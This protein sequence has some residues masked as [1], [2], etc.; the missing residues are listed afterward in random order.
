[1][2]EMRLIA[3]LAVLALAAGCAQ[4]TAQGPTPSLSPE[5]S[6]GP[7]PTAATTPSPPLP[8]PTAA[9]VTKGSFKLT[10][11]AA[12]LKSPIYVTAAGDGSDRL[13]VVEQPGRILV[14]KNGQVLPRPFLDIRSLVAYGGERGLLGLAFHPDFG[15]NGVFVVDYTR[16]SGHVGDTVIARYKAVPGSDVAD[17]TSAQVLMVISQPQ[18][19]HNGGM[20][21]FGPDRYLYIGMGDGGAGG[22]AGAGHAPQGNGQSLT[23]L[24]GKLLRIDVGATGSYAIPTTNPRLSP[25]ARREIWAYGLRNPWR[26]SFDRATGALYIGDVGQNA[27]EEID[28]RPSSSKGGENYGWPVFEG[29]HTYRGGSLTGDVKPVTQYPHSGGDCSVSGGYVYRGQKIPSMFGFYLFGDYC[30]GRVRTLV[31]FQGQWRTS[32]LLDTSY[33][34]SSFGQD[35]AGELYLVNLAGQVYRFDPA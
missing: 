29:T 2:A 16:S 11:V 4:Q 35:D 3:G 8:S 18:A 32:L 1:M 21:T 7:T 26:F 9:T 14:M 23:T 30:S 31:N 28:V 34:I 24:L 27:W 12:G 25:T 17:P 13:F 6:P 20:V 15:L 10:R 19:N 33:L 5:T 22:D